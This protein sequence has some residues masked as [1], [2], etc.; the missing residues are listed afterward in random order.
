M[1]TSKK[2]ILFNLK[3]RTNQLTL[4]PNEWPIKIYDSRHVNLAF[5]RAH[6]IVTFPGGPLI[7]WGNTPKQKA[8]LLKW[9]FDVAW[10]CNGGRGPIHQWQG[11]VYLL[12]PGSCIGNH[13]IL[14]PKQSHLLCIVTTQPACVMFLAWSKWLVAKQGCVVP[15]RKGGCDSLVRLLASR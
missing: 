6:V 14:P 2:Q 15:L 12:C 9:R 5:Y 10:Y 8:P 13:N 7:Q 11:V 1:A 3:R 4:R